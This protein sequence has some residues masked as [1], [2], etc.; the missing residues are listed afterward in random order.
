MAPSRARGYLRGM[1]RF[2]KIA[3][4]AGIALIALGAVTA[5]FWP[6]PGVIVIGIGLIPF[7]RA[8]EAGFNPWGIP[9][10]RK[11][12]DAQGS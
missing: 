8:I 1:E 9:S 12:S 3:L 5:C 7:G 4:G 6:I 11:K 2:W 10:P